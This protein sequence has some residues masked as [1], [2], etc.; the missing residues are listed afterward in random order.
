[1]VRLR[2]EA[3]YRSRYR[4]SAAHVV[5]TV[6]A[7]CTQRRGGKHVAFFRRDGVALSVGGSDS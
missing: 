3:L 1:M 6:V 2:H 7:L 5:I 4:I